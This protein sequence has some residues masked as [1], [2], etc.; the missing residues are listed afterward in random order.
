ML[1][2]VFVATLGISLGATA[3][4]QYSPYDDY[5][6]GPQYVGTADRMLAADFIAAGGGPG[7]FSFVRAWDRMIGRSEMEGDIDQLAATYGW[8]DTNR[9]IQMANF[10]IA[11]SWNRY[12]ADNIHMPFPSSVPGLSLA[13]AIVR[14][15]E[16]PTGNLWTD[17]MLGQL[18]GPRAYSEVS[19]DIVDRYGPYAEKQ[20]TRVGNDF[21]RLVAQQVGM[22]NS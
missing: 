22:Y 11:D 1:T 2:V 15:G 19:A 7:S 10:A 3:L 20:F 21:L 13:Q 17:Y 12:G 9:F 14:A 5:S 4:A 18:D 6:K 8:H 16:G